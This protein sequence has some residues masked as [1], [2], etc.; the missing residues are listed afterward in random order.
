MLLLVILRRALSQH[1]RSSV[2]QYAGCCPE[3]EPD[4]QTCAEFPAEHI[5]AKVNDMVL[6]IPYRRSVTA[7]AVPKLDEVA[8]QAGN[9]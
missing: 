3:G 8:V 6:Q 1:R 5:D 2:Q 4:W 9:A 7:S